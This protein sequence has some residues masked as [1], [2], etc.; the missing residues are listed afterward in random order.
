MTA[1]L[2][3]TIETMLVL[4]LIIFVVTLV[5]RRARVPYTIALVVTGLL[6]FEPGFRNIE[7]TP[8]LILTLFLPLL[9]FEGAYNVSARSLWRNLLPVT[10]LAVPGVLFSTIVTAAL[11]H[12]RHCRHLNRRA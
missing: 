7:L 1:S 5:A 3:A 12:L 8:D 11:I 9:L 6:G 4:L 2:H 10:L